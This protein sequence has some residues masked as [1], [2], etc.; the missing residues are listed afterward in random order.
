MLGDKRRILR[1]TF[2]EIP[3]AERRN[4]IDIVL[5]YNITHTKDDI[6]LTLLLIITESITEFENIYK[7]CRVMLFDTEDAKQT[8]TRLYILLLGT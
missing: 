4:I 5:S 6:G 7:F 8:N 3:Y 1:E 2:E